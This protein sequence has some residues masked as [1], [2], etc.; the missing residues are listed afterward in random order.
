MN[1][2][3]YLSSLVI[4]AGIFFSCQAPAQNELA[5]KEE[6][7]DQK[8]EVIILPQNQLSEKLEDQKTQLLDVR[9]LEEVNQGIIPGA[10]H[11]DY[12]DQTAFESVSQNLDK[13]LPVVVYC[14]AG[15]RS[16]K[17][18]LWLTENGFTEVYD[19]EG[20]YNSWTGGQ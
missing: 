12:L 16:K 13:T 3:K 6:T 11:M 19:L 20:G 2:K 5:V 18:A 15:G 7:S 10:I 14:A 8:G 9:T 4:C 17:A 1:L